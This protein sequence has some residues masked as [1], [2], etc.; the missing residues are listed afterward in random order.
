MNMQFGWIV[1]AGLALSAC[2][3]ASSSGDDASTEAQSNSAQE[4]TTQQTQTAS[5]PS[6]FRAKAPNPNP[7]MYSNAEVRI[8]DLVYDMPYVEC[9]TPNPVTGLFAVTTQTTRSNKT[10]PNFWMQGKVEDATL[11]FFP[12]RATPQSPLKT[13]ISYGAQTAIGFEDNILFYEGIF[14]VNTNG[15]P[16][17]EQF[18][19]VTVDCNK[20][21]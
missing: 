3:G 10:G 19:A 9:T 17:G 6:P 14:E 7:H 15:V 16:T 2:G 12:A 20:A 13:S 1:A 18:V 11:R 4:H 8:N 5:A 21:Q